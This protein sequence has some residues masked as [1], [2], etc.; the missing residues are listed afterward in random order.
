MV[1]LVSAMLVDIT[2]LRVFLGVLANIIYCYFVV[3]VE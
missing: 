1:I 2:H 3:R